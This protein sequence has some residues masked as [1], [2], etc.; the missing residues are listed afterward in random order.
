MNLNKS[1]S[2]SNSAARPWLA[3]SNQDEQAT[4]TSAVIIPPQLFIGSQHNDSRGE[5]RGPLQA[6]SLLTAAGPSD[7]AEP[8]IN[9]R[10]MR[11]LLPSLVQA[12]SLQ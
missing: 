12:K 3:E 10:L 6:P 1:G 9:E 5:Y 8:G 2:D 7:A 4:A 11:S